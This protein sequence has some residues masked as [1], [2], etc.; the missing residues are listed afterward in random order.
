MRS[1][2][3][4]VTAAAPAGGMSSPK[5]SSAPVSVWPANSSARN[6]IRRTFGARSTVLATVIVNWSY[7]ARCA[8]AAITSDTALSSTF[9]CSRSSVE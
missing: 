9:I 6:V 8:G 5:Y 2:L 1:S 4:M 3:G 7:T